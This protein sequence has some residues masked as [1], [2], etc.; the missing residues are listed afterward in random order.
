[1]NDKQLAAE[2]ERRTLIAQAVREHQS[3]IETE[4][5]RFLTELDRI[6]VVCDS[7]TA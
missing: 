6:N 4:M 2:A 7:R 1:M 5:R 3:N